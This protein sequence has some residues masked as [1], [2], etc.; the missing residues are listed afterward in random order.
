[1]NNKNLFSQRN[2]VHR[3]GC[4]EAFS[5]TAEFLNP[6][7]TQLERFE[8]ALGIYSTWLARVIIQRMGIK[9]NTS[10]SAEHSAQPALTSHPNNCTVGVPS[11]C[12]TGG[13][14]K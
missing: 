1:M 12:K 7:G 5:L 2:C 4:S 14:N 13:S 9:A 3:I 11:S 8:N 10:H 6:T